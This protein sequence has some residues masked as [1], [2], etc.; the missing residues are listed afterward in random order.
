[1]GHREVVDGFGEE[2]I[3]YSRAIMNKLMCWL[4]PLVVT[5]SSE[6]LI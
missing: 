6:I 5:S 3:P 1:V 2:K 4:G